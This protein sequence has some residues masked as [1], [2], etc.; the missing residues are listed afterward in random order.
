ML[1]PLFKS[2][3]TKWHIFTPE[4]ARRVNRNRSLI[5][6]YNNIAYRTLIFSCSTKYGH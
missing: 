5:D 3:I 1:M 6:I 4:F 2:T